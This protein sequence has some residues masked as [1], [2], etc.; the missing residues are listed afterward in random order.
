ME[1]DF[2]LEQNQ[3]AERKL[4]VTAVNVGTTETPDW[5]VVGA[6]VEDSSIELNPDVST[7]TDICGITE[8]TVNKVEPKQSFEPYTIR[9]GSK[10]AY[11]LFDIWQRKAWSELANFEV[12]LMY[13]FIGGATTGTFAAEK[14]IGCTIAIQ[15]IGGS[16][17]V[18][19]PIEIT[20]SNDSTLG[21]VNKLKGANITFTPTVPVE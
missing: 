18:D 19:M 7:V 4:L 21:T 1:N 20:Y 3:K 17:T 16:A 11:K 13:G 8:T 14:Q 15:S 5:E 2:K 12:L 9:G 10:L 6:G